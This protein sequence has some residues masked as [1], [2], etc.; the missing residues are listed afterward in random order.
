M[1]LVF[2]LGSV[3]TVG[4]MYYVLRKTD[5]Q[6]LIKRFTVWFMFGVLLA[7]TPIFFEFLA[8]YIS[9]TPNPSVL[10]VN[11]ELFMVSVAI[12]ANACGYLMLS[13]TDNFA[14]KIFSSGSLI[15]LVVVSSLLFA[16]MSGLNTDSYDPIKVRFLSVI[17]FLL[18]LS[19][20]ASCVLLA[21]NE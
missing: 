16:S 5:N 1:Y 4:V 7:L 12:G 20:S 9:K 17:T 14:L 10:L 21:D 3:L 15:I 18:T 19:F 2:V 8:T 13:G 6:S 11:G